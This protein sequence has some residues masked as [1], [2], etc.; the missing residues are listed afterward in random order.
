MA[1]LINLPGYEVP[2]NALLDLAPIN[3]ALDFSAQQSGQAFKAGQDT[4][5][6]GMEQTRFQ[7][8]QQDRDAMKLARGALVVHNIDAK[9]P[10]RQQVWQRLVQS[11]PRISAELQK[12]GVDPGDHVQGPQF[13]LSEA[14]KYDPLKELAA[15]AQIR[16]SE[17]ST[18]HTM[19]AE[20]RAKDLHS[21]DVLMKD[22][23]LNSPADKLTM[24]PEGG[25]LVRTDPRTG[26]HE[27]VAQGGEKIDATTKKAIDE[28]DDFVAQTRTALGALQEATRLNKLA[29]DGAAAGARATVVN[30]IPFTGGGTQ[31]S[32]ATTNLENVVT[33][34]AVQSLRPVFGG[35]PTEGERKILVELAGSVNQP[36]A[37][38]QDIY[39]RAMAMAQQRLS[40][41]QQKAQS[42]RSGQYY[43]AGGQPAAVDQP[44][45]L[46]PQSQHG[47]QP[48]QPAA[49]PRARNPQTGQVIEFDGRQWVEVR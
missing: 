46:A 43:K 1:A 36:A 22:R 4:A 15:K 12:Y 20:G 45:N 7:N 17:A 40:I 13:I 9:D 37:V 29:Y 41:N 21:Y 2:R 6:L 14:G 11:D 33:N 27:T 18:A 10:R 47:A 5:R 38:R 32:Q 35:N 16:A 31:S 19:G 49:R 25:T 8:E 30:N 48:Q 42:L 23:E 44:M 28:A 34:Q 3:N 26:R 39:N 24:V